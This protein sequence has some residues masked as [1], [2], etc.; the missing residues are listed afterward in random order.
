[1]PGSKV[2]PQRRRALALALA[3]SQ[4]WLDR[5]NVLGLAIGCRQRGGRYDD[6]L[7][8]VVTVGRKM[9]L[10][11]LR[12][13]RLKPL[14]AVVDVQIDRRRVRIAVD[15]QMVEERAGRLCS[16]GRQVYR[17]NTHV[18]TVGLVVRRGAQR[19]LITA[20]H[21]VDAIGDQ[22]RVGNMS[23][24]VVDR[25]WR[26]R[27]DQAL[28]K[29]PDG[30]TPA[31]TLPN[32]GS[33]ATKS[34]LLGPGLIHRSCYLFRAGAKLPMRTTVRVVDA[35]VPFAA[36][37]HELADS[38]GHLRMRGLVG[39]D[40]VA[41]DGDSGTA[42]FDLAFRLVGTLVGTYGGH[43]YFCPCT[44]ALQYWKVQPVGE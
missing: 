23:A 31:G 43:D 26:W 13:S 24:T 41:G 2:S 19:F 22:L 15:V 37:H 40:A 4:H 1:M 10:Q 5:G 17:N 27:V 3:Q 42:L 28:L 30:V 33:L 32:G 44:W 11:E 14:P 7:C 38:S 21:V 20:G 9:P 36:P 39:V 8:L 35:I 29:P 18:G 6:E 34:A 12:A 16:P 25:M